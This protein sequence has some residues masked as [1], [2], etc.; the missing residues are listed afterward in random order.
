MG[1]RVCIFGA[2]L[3]PSRYNPEAAQSTESLENPQKPGTLTNIP[4]LFTHVHYGVNRCEVV[5]ETHAALFEGTKHVVLSGNH[6][7]KSNITS[8]TSPEISSQLR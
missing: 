6:N 1:L 2:K 7:Y 5:I 3:P 4:A 8:P